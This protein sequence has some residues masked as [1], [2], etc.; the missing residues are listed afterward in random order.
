MLV[1]DRCL[2]WLLCLF[3][4]VAGDLQAL[5]VETNQL[6][7]KQKTVSNNS[8]EWVTKISTQEFRIGEEGTSFL[9]QLQQ[10]APPTTWWRSAHM[11]R[12][13]FSPFH[14]SFERLGQK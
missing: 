2:D 8:E 9:H 13:L 12:G 4:V 1:C 7:Q 6:K 10:F 3:K 5:E 11:S 14:V